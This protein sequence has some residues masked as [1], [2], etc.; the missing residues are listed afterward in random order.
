MASG[1]FA[2]TKM[3]HLSDIETVAEK[4]NPVFVAVVRPG[5]PAPQKVHTVRGLVTLIFHGLKL[6]LDRLKA[7]IPHRRF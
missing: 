6:P 1:I 5:P 3:A 7:H 2:T 4:G